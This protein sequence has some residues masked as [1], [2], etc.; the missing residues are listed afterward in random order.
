MKSKAEHDVLILWLRGE[1]ERR[2]ANHCRM[3][4]GQ[5][6]AIVNK[7][8]FSNRASMSDA[9]RAKALESL[10]PAGPWMIRPLK[11]DASRAP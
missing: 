4:R 3:R 2:I 5:V 10:V 11:P 1:T 8:D 7:S 9:D 6:A